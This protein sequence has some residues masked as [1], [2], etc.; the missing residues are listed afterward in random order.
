MAI[1]RMHVVPGEVK[2]QDMDPLHYKY[3][4]ELGGPKRRCGAFFKPVCRIEGCHR[5]LNSSNLL[6]AD[7]KDGTCGCTRMGYKIKVYKRP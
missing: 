7:G 1:L 3:R 6:R 2:L 5:S 4:D